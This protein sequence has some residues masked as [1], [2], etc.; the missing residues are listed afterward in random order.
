MRMGNFMCPYRIAL[1]VMAA[2]STRGGIQHL[3]V[4]PTNFEP[5]L[6]SDSEEDPSES[7][8]ETSSQ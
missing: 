7:N 6:E 4:V 5:G 3:T 8:S 1:I 2:R